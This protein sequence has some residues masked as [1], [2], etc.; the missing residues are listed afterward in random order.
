VSRA[1]GTRPGRLGVFTVIAA[2]L[3]GLIITLVAGTEP[4]V[5][6]GAFIVA[7]TVAGS[8]AVRVSAVYLILPVPAPAY[9]VAACIAGLVHD[10]ATDTSHT[11]LALNAVQWIANGFI[12]MTISTVL[13]CAIAALR[14]ARNVHRAQLDAA[15]STDRHRPG[16]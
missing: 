11:A 5:V 12:A 6:L 9:A 15:A 4:G 3:L 7:G 14:W 1:W 10:H 2:G 16:A 13:A 8:L